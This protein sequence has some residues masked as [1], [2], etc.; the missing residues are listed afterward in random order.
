VI[1]LSLLFF[2]LTMGSLAASP[3]QGFTPVSF[4]TSMEWKRNPTK[5]S[6]IDDANI[7]IAEENFRK[8]CEICAAS[9]D[10]EKPPSDYSIPPMIHFIWLGSPVPSKVQAVIASWKTCHPGWEI[11]IWT[12]AEAAYFPWSTPRL[13]S[14]FIEASTWSEKSDLLRFEVLYQWGGIYSDTDVVCFKSLCDLITNG[15]TFFAGFERNFVTPNR[16]NPLYI[17]SA[18]MGAIKNSPVMKY[19]LEDYKTARETPV[20]YV[21][22]AGP[23][24]VSRA[25]H[26]ALA[27]ADRKSI[28][29]LPCSYFYPLPCK[30][31]WTPDEDVLPF[32]SSES[33]TVHL[34]DRSWH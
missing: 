4:W 22:R 25:C 19:C 18:V 7:Q 8:F 29:I 27:S 17:G 5:P 34:W 15:L 12:D 11:R 32:V 10:Y 3:L 9:S 14:A 30:S 26:A 21:M 20:G 13:H 2:F 24:V 23:G 6:F 28:L 33:F 16:K 31:A 1:Y